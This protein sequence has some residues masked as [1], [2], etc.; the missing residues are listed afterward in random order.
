M[1]MMTNNLLLLFSSYA[2]TFVRS[3]AIEWLGQLPSDELLDYLPQL[4]QALKFESF[5]TS[6]LARL[7]LERSVL[8]LRVA[9]ML[10]W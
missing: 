2:D 5:H 7:L 4:V 1:R 6:A 9:H 10:Y 3:K 8:S